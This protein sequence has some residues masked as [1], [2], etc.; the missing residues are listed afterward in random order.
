MPIDPAGRQQHAVALE[1]I[2][3]QFLVRRLLEAEHLAAL[4][5]EAR[6][7]VF[8][9][10]VFAGRIHRLQ[11][12]QHGICIASPEQLLGCGELFAILLENLHRPFFHGRFAGL[13]QFRGVSPTGIAIFQA[14]FLPGSTQN[15]SISSGLIIY[16]RLLLLI[17]GCGPN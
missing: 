6:H 14:N 11:H 7:D 16:C 10:A 9:R 5:V 17:L 4:R 12:D 1:E 3:L 15:W 13:F 2:V 8:D